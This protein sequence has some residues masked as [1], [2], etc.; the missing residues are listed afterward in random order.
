MWLWG[1]AIRSERQ[2]KERQLRLCRET[3][4]GRSGGLA[5]RLLSSVSRPAQAAPLDFLQRSVP[6]LPA[7]LD[8]FPVI[9]SA[10][11]TMGPRWSYE[12]QFFVT[13]GMERKSSVISP[14]LILFLSMLWATAGFLLISENSAHAFK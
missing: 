5:W 14:V 4:E 10:K 9:F 7:L 2:L 1:V 12:H 13:I 6:L 8:G 3:G 11:I